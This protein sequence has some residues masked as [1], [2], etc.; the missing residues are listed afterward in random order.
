MKNIPSTSRLGKYHTKQLLQM[1]K[2]VRGSAHYFYEKPEPLPD[3]KEAH[4]HCRYNENEIKQS[5][6][7]G[8][9]Y[10]LSMFPSEWVNKWIDQK[11]RQ[12]PPETPIRTALCP[13]CK[14][15]SVLAEQS[16]F[17]ITKEFLQRM[18]DHWFESPEEITID[19][20]KAELATRPHVPNKQEARK[21]RQEKAK[22]RG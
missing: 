8:C 5:T 6:R 15:D 3:I 16:G 22:K 2:G 10:C 9:F 14:I 1:L 7:C 20:L 19:D 18:Y 13:K 12:T 11:P 4:K 21:I 17:P